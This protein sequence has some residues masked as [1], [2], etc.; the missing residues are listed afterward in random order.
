MD[1]NCAYC[2][3]KLNKTQLVFMKC[4][5]EKYYCNKHKIPEKHE[6]TFDYKTAYQTKLA[7]NNK[8]IITEKLIKI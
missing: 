2:Q 8:Q 5:C 1:S 6:C 7:V 4:K 3:I